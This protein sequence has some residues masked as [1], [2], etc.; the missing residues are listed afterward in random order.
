[1]I[2]EAVLSCYMFCYHRS[3]IN[4]TPII[5]I[6]SKGYTT[7]IRCRIHSVAYLN[8]Y[9]RLSWATFESNA[10]RCC[11]QPEALSFSAFAASGNKSN[12][13]SAAPKAIVLTISQIDIN[14][15]YN[16]V[17]KAMKQIYVI[18]IQ[19]SQIQL[20]SGGL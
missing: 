13:S 16:V 4:L 18:I 14:Q 9:F 10:P 6:V 2:V 8:S 20:D 17:L 3:L 7:L 11:G 5:N 1:M 19:L 12:G 15:L